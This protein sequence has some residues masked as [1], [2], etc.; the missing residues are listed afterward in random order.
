MVQNQMRTVIKERK[1]VKV[2]TEK[3]IYYKY[4]PSLGQELR[5]LKGKYHIRELKT[6]EKILTQ[7]LV[8][9][10]S[11]LCA[12]L[13]T[14]LYCLIFF[15]EL[16]YNLRAGERNQSVLHYFRLYEDKIC[17]NA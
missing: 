1:G 14:S 9:V 3:S 4:D 16:S 8:V 13:T 12:Q 6:V 10:C 11:K 7:I 2:H 5:F 15:V 17:R